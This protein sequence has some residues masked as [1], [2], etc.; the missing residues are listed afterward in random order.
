MGAWPFSEDEWRAVSDAA[1][2]VVNAGMAEDEVLNAS[3][4]ITLREVL[5]DLRSRHGDHPW[6]LE[7]EAD[8]GDEDSERVELY[9]QAV[10]IATVYDMQTL[11]IRLA[12][13]QTFLNA[14]QSAKA[15]EALLA[16]RDEAD[17]T[18]DSSDRQE[19][20]DLLAECERRIA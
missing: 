4:L 8:F 12:L 6:L 2:A 19:W 17:D 20:A 1:L 14:C 13:A 11:T 7:T 5:A 18:K 15:R 3:H 10:R 9:E 16:C